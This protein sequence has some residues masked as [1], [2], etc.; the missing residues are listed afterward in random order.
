MEVSTWGKIPGHFLPTVS[1]SA[2][3]CSRVVTHGDA[4][5]RK[6]EHLTQIAQLALKAAVR[7]VKNNKSAILRCFKYDAS[8]FFKKLEFMELI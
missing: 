6:L 2:A 1:P 4:W 5:W 7:K 8:C 3:G